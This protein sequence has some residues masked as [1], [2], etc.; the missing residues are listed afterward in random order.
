MSKFMRMMAFHLVIA[1]AVFSFTATLVNA[2]TEEEL[3][4]S[5]V[6]ALTLFEAKRYSESIPHFELLVKVMPDAPQLRFAYGFALLAKSKQDATPEEA[7]ILSAKALEQ[8]KAA[9]Q[10][11]LN[12]PTNESLIKLLSGEINSED[13]G[14][15][16]ENPEANKSMNQGEAYFAQGKY[17]DAL[18]SFQ[19]AL[20]LDP[21]IYQAA[22]SGADSY[23]SKGDLANAE[24]WY[25][26]AIK[27]DPNRE[28]AYRY[29]ATPLMQQEKY[30]E[31]R[32]RYIEALITEPYSQMSPRGITQ[33]AQVTG[34]KLGHPKVDIP[35]VSYDSAGKPTTKMNE[36]SL[37]EGSKAWL[38]YS[39]ARENWYKEKFA[40]TFPNEKKYRHTLQEEAEAIRSTLKSAKDQ[41]LSHPDFDILQKLDTDGLLEAFILMSEAD[42]GI[43][44]DH[45]EYLKNNR[46]KLRQYVLN[47][48]I[49]K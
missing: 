28:T 3:K 47:Y 31:A 25:Q 44:E 43:A 17:D 14:S 30:D 26:K 8:F 19:K 21:T 41:N 39:L 10:H 20:D 24:I 36:N 18:K 7:Q 33:W 29:S 15:Y 9:K 32:D 38:A 27:I 22:V 12:D 4:E 2:Q 6:K 40:K 35:E 16:S 13:E 5:M 48:V 46:A 11:G 42:E 1:I 45:A 49:K 37:T 23:L 34:A